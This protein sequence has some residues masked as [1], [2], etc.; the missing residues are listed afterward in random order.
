ML[1]VLVVMPHVWFISIVWVPSSNV[2][3]NTTWSIPLTA[4]ENGLKLRLEFKHSYIDGWLMID[5]RRDDN[6]S[7][8]KVVDIV[9]K[10]G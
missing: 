4:I 10:V 3:Y 5:C 7:R 6:I 8:D 9:T 2:T 1:S